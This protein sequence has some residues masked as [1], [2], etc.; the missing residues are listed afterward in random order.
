LSTTN[1]PNTDFATY[2]PA[3]FAAVLANATDTSSGVIIDLSIG[4]DAGATLKLANITKGQLE[5]DWFIF[6]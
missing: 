2:H 3:N 5:S 6:V 4:V 1:T